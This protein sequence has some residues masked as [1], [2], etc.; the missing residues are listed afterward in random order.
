MAFQSS[1]IID[2]K[3]CPACQGKGCL[4]CGQFGVVGE[5]DHQKLIFNLPNSIETGIRKEQFKDLLL[6]RGLIVFVLIIL[7]IFSW[8]IIL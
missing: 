7:I 2:I 8:I 3:T 5:I 4:S 1:Q 6:K